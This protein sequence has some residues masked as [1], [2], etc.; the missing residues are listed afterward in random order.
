MYVARIYRW[1]G[2]RREQEVHIHEENIVHYL[3]KHLIMMGIDSDGERIRRH[4]SGVLQNTV[5]LIALRHAEPPPVRHLRCR[6]LEYFHADQKPSPCPR[7]KVIS[8]ILCSQFGHI[9]LVRTCHV[10]DEGR[11][12][13]RVPSW[14]QAETFQ[15]AGLHC[16][17]GFGRVGS[18]MLHLAPCQDWPEQQPHMNSV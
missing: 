2:Q 4:G 8:E 17:Q 6:L 10:D 1:T 15:R 7:A 5:N 13:L 9:G 18:S 3:R 16:S 14:D 11:R 12:A